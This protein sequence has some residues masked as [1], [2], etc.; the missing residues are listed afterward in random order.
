MSLEDFVIQKLLDTEDKLKDAEDK[1][2]KN[3]LECNEYMEKIARIIEILQPRI[4]SSEFLGAHIAMNDISYKYE[5]D[6]FMEI[7]NIF[8]LTKKDEG[9]DVGASDKTLNE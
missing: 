3:F 4:E 9:E 5:P 8:K 2:V 1:L 6:E 7:V